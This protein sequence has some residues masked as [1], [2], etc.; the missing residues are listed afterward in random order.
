MKIGKVTTLAELGTGAGSRVF[1]V[2]REEDSREYALKVADVGS[3][4]TRKYL[5]QAQN[6]YD[7][8]GLLDH[9]NLM[10]VHCIETE[11]G[12]FSGP[13]TVRLLSEF[14]P[15]K[16]MNLLP[17]QTVLRLVQIFERIA[18]AVAHMHSRGVI[19]CDLKP[20]NVVL[21]TG[22]RIKV[23]DFGVAYIVGT[24][25]SGLCT[26]PE[27]MA[28]ETS[29][30]RAINEKTDIYS[31]GVTMYRL[32]TL[33]FPPSPLNAVILGERGYE[34]QYRSVT[35]LNPD[36]PDELADLIRDCLRADPRHRPS[37]M[38]EIRQTLAKIG[39]SLRRQIPQSP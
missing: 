23:I 39:D 34:R 33:Q 12:W 27:F 9:P 26:T 38:E 13:R 24:P 22:S 6:E 16:A 5:S 14:A 25:K 18:S 20:S 21:D 4:Q 8:A 11:G 32:A 28:P 10:R 30:H 19:H 31:L 17:L 36:V 35:S 37:S 29:T 7:V 2:H 15:G 1:L 3:P